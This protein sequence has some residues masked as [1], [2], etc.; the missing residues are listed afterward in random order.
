[1][2]QNEAQIPGMYKGKKTSQHHSQKFKRSK[3]GR[4]SQA[5]SAFLH[6]RSAKKHLNCEVHVTGNFC[7]HSH[8]LF[9]LLIFSTLPETVLL[10]SSLQTAFQLHQSLFKLQANKALSV[11]RL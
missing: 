8:T 9:Y 4:P 2:K 5:A 10:T 7:P 3:T 11:Y 1:M 6:S